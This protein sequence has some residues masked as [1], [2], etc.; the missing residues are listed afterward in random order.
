VAAKP[1]HSQAADHYRTALDL[2]TTIGDP[3]E[4]AHAHAGLALSYRYI[5]RADDA[6]EHWQVALR[7]YQALGVPEAAEVQHQ[8]EELDRSANSD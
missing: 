5:G 2:T 7:I 8:L 1:R 6:L 3:Y 4:Q